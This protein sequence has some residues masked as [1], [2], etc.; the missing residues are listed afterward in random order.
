MKLDQARVVLTGATGGIGAV[1]ANALVRA[2]AAVMLVGR[3]AARLAALAQ[4]LSRIDADASARV[5]VQ[6]ADLGDT[7]AIDTLA[8]AAAVWRANVLVHGAGVPAFGA[9]DTL[10]SD[11][12]LH[13][14][15]TNLVAP[16]LLTR[17]LL[18]HLRRQPRAQVVCIGSALGRIGL[19]GFSVY[20]A[21][22]FG[23]RGFSEALRRELAGGPVR[24]QYLGPRT[25]RTGFNDAAVESYNRAT[26]TASDPP[27]L[28]AT[29]LLAMIEHETAE[30]FLGFP[31]KAAVRLNGA[32]GP[33]LDVAFIRHRQ[34]LHAPATS[35]APTPV[36]IPE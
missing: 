27:L 8:A 25:T 4:E 7:N 20:S 24:V 35:L 12:V 10:P 16:V 33:L 36:R 2:G 3:S 29:A 30:R 31:E 9:L 15:Q 22:K 5:A 23:L 21:G 28:V 26:G 13:V 18:P 34:A 1:T 19:P 11:Q 6:V 32:V 17:A 14:L